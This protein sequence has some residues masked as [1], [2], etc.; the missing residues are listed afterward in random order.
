MMM[1]KDLI[2]KHLQEHKP[3]VINMGKGFLSDND[4]KEDV[5]YDEEIQ[6]YRSDTGVYSNKLIREIVNGEVPN[7]TIEIDN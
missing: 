5:W 7:T 4:V 6:K 2:F 1:T 3:I